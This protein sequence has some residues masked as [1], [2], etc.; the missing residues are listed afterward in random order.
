M[1]QQM[2]GRASRLGRR[3]GGRVVRSVPQLAQRP[4]PDGLGGDEAARA[5]A[6]VTRLE[7]QLALL[8][9]R[10]N[11]LEQEVQEQRVL[12]RRLAELADIVQELLLPAVHRDDER[13]AALMDDYAKKL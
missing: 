4:G 12:N 11:E 8:R 5:D 9:E 3:V 1:A 10:V 7:S 6:T 13:L 2:W